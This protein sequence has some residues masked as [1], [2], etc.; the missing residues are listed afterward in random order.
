L[1]CY[2]LTASASIQII[3]EN[4]K[5]AWIYGEREKKF[6]ERKKLFWDPSTHFFQ[7]V[8]TDGIFPYDESHSRPAYT[9]AFECDTFPMVCYGRFSFLF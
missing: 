6:V 8:K 4:D 7:G 3:S 2:T 9:F 5:T 1:L